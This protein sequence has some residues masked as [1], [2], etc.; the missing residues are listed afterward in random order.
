MIVKSNLPGNRV[1]LWER[2]PD[3]PDGEV[4]IAGLD[5]HKVAETPAVKAALRLGNLVEV[6][7]PPKPKPRKRTRKAAG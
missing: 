3:H 6:K 5:E 7:P 2:H 4:L 1:A